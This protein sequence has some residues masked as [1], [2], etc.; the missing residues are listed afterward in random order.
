MV[1]SISACESPASVPGE[2]KYTLLGMESGILGQCFTVVHPGNYGEIFGQNSVPTPVGKIDGRS[3]NSRAMRTGCGSAERRFLAARHPAIPDPFICHR[4][5]VSRSK[6]SRGV[7]VSS[8]IGKFLPNRRSRIADFIDDLLQL[9][10]GYTK[11]SGPVFHFPTFVHVDLASVGRI[12]LRQMIH[13]YTIKYL[14]G[15]ANARK[16][17]VH[18]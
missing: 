16:G 1:I 18:R 6:L 2:R 11:L 10:S 4:F 7:G 5:L 13:F 12:P 14:R 15:S 8:A 17:V 3:K 9:G